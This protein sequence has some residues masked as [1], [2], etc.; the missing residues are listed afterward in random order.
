MTN[1]LMVVAPVGGL[2]SLDESHG[3]LGCELDKV[4]DVV[5]DDEGH[6]LQGTALL[7]ESLESNLR[8]DL[9]HDHA[10]DRLGHQLVEA[11]HRLV[12]LEAKDAKVDEE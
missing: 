3:K 5:L 8:R 9:D 10:G 1:M 12:H 2:D 4:L 6:L 11:D 7:R